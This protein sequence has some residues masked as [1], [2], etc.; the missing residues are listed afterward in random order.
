[1]QDCLPADVIAWGTD[2]AVFHRAIPSQ[3]QTLE[4][5]RA[6]LLESGTDAPAK[7]KPP[8]IVRDAPLRPFQLAYN[9]ENGFYLCENRGKVQG[10]CCT[11]LAVE[12]VWK[13]L[14]DDLVRVS[15][16]R[17]PHG[18]QIKKSERS[19]F[20][21]EL[22]EL[23]PDAALTR[24]DLKAITPNP[25]QVGPVVGVS[26]PRDG[27]ICKKCGVGYTTEGSSAFHW[28]T[29]HGSSPDEKPKKPDGTPGQYLRHGF[30]Y[31]PQMQT[32]SLH[33]GSI[34]W[35]EIVPAPSEV[36]TGGRTTS[37]DLE[38][39]LDLETE[40]FGQASDS[41]PI[42]IDDASLLEFW[43]TSGASE[44]IKEYS[45]A[46][47]TALVGLPRADEPH[48]VK[49]RRAQSLRYMSA[50]KRV[51]TASTAIRRL[52]VTTLP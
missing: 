27:Y 51:S 10:M 11:G 2:E 44:H 4:E 47:L 35:F 43:R 32:L 36:Q 30:Q 41:M 33:S 13:H 20:E 24:E 12:E 45:P 25:G 8:V 31:V 17:L 7:P 42:E 52:L 40:V 3:P 28:R 18:Y 15:S 23:H 46:D 1:L 37:S 26:P 21:K 50:C 39:L 9:T 6:A 48:L 16:D 34:R 5:F 49:L 22:V 38:T 29:V 14:T 19:R